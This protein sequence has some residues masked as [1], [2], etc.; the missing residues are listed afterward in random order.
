MVGKFLAQKVSSGVTGTYVPP[1]Y[2]LSGV[3]LTEVCVADLTAIIT[4][5]HVNNDFPSLHP[6]NDLQSQPL[7]YLY[8]LTV[9]EH[10]FHQH[11]DLSN[12]LNVALEVGTPCT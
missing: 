8:F 6:Q 12:L 3:A 11:N 10:L 4:L 7:A 5:Q 9:L 2:Q 1:F